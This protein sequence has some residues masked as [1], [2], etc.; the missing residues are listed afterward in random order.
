MKIPTEVTVYLKTGEK[1]K[2]YEDVPDTDV[3]KML[4][5]LKKLETE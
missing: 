1:H 4:T 5:E 2:T 3:V